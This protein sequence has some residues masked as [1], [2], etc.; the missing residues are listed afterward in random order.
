MSRAVL[1]LDLIDDPSR[2]GSGRNGSFIA[3][4]SWVDPA[5]SR[6]SPAAARSR[7]A[8]ASSAGATSTRTPSICICG[9]CPAASSAD[10]AAL[11]P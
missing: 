4:R 5:Y 8:E 9:Y 10:A 6:L 11:T 3:E 2:R 7:Q 1:G